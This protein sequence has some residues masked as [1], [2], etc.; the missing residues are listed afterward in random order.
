MQFGRQSIADP[1]FANKLREGR[2]EDVRPC[3]VCNEECIGRIFGRLTQLSCTVNPSVGFESYMEV[4]PV[5]KPT[6][7]RRHRRRPRRPRG[8]ALRCRA[9]RLLRHPLREGRPIWAAPS[10]PS[11][12]A[13]SSGAC[14]SSSSG[15]SVQLEKLGVKVVL[16]TEVSADDPVLKSADAIFVATGS[17]SFMPNIPGIDNKKV[18]DVV[19][20]HKDGMPEGKNVVICGGG[21]SACDTAIEYGAKGGRHISIVEML[22]DVGND[23]IGGQQD[24]RRPPAQGVQTSNC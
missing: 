20:V 18:I 16:S 2:R 3:I 1:Q 15:T 4:K 21:L 10:S 14:R 9:R 23:V 19:D 17:K 5:S 12:P 6:K 24:K 13:T 7:R 11:P 22:P 8:R